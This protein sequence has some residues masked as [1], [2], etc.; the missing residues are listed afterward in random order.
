M[1]DNIHLSIHLHNIIHILCSTTQRHSP[2]PSDRRFASFTPP[3]ASKSST[4]TKK[5]VA[6]LLIRRQLP[7][8]LLQLLPQP[9]PQIPALLV[10]RRFRIQLQPELNVGTSQVIVIAC[11]YISPLT[12][13]SYHVFKNYYIAVIFCPKGKLAAQSAIA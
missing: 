13:I 2:L 3:P 4:S 9:P 10:Q 6:S 7:V 5:L 12:A 8:H 1:Y 11:I